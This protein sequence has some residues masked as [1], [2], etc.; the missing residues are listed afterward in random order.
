MAATKKSSTAMWK[1]AD[2]KTRDLNKKQSHE[3]EY[4]PERK[5]PPKKLGSKLIRVFR[6]SDI[7][8]YSEPFAFSLRIVFVVVLI[9]RMADGIAQINAH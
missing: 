8:T 3:L 7:L 6:T 5:G 2:R 9:A 1:K 4:A